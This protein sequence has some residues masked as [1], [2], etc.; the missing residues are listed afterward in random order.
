MSMK[1]VPNFPQTATDADAQYFYKEGATGAGS[2]GIN[3]AGST[4]AFSIRQKGYTGIFGNGL[5]GT[6]L[7][8][9]LNDIATAESKAGNLLISIGGI[10]HVIVIYR[11]S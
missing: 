4:G 10:D 6:N 1:V 3:Q 7:Q 8:T 5:T 2:T 9:A 11:N